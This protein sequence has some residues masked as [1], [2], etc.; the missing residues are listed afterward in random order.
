[1]GL[2]GNS[3]NSSE[4]HLHFHL[5]DAN[6]PL[7]SEGI[8]YALALFS[9]KAKPGAAETEHKIEIPSEDEIVVF[10]AKP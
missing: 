1:V 4:P 10:P 7:G 3:G 9:A 8:P 6:S 5:S 2:V